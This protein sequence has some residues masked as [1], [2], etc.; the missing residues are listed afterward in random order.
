M[1]ARNNRHHDNPHT[2]MNPS[3]TFPPAHPVLKLT[4]SGVTTAPFAPSAEKWAATLTE[5]R[6][7]LLEDH[8]ALRVREDNLRD[9]ETRLRALQAEIEAGRSAQP[10]SLRATN[11]PFMRP[12]SRAP[13]SDDTALQAAWEKL[14]RARAILEAEQPHLR[15]DRI[16][17]HDQQAEMKR[18]E[19]S[20]AAREA[21]VAEREQLIAAATVPVVAGEPIASEHTMSA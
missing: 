11:A 13:F 2:T 9:Y 6:R 17:L 3:I 4:R 18:R 8:E 16:R 10:V 1:S 7:R 14:Y 19:E 20:V 5:E 12:S 15:D 21:S